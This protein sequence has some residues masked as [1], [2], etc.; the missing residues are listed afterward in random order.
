MPSCN[1]VFAPDLLFVGLSGEDFGDR[2]AGQDCQNPSAD[3]THSMQRDSAED[4]AARQDS[5]AS[6]EDKR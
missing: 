5:Q 6:H 3:E 1:E 4:P 2:A